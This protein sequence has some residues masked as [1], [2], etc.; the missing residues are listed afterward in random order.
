MDT[1][2]DVR[3]NNWALSLD[4][5]NKIVQGIDEI[6]QCILVILSTQKGSD[7]FR[8]EFGCDIFP[9]IDLPIQRA[10]TLMIKAIIEAIEIW[11]TR[12]IVK[13]ITT[14]IMDGSKLSFIIEWEA[15]NS[16]L[17]GSTQ[18]NI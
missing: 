11:E 13:K 18:F 9:Y 7:P 17:G 15:V 12:V 16:D 1:L 3:T 2:N 6:S 10:K 5:P 14:E 4:N 8:P